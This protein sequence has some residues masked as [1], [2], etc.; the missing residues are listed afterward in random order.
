M[1][2]DVSK[3]TKAEAAAFVPVCPF[4][5]RK[6]GAYKEPEPLV[7]VDRISDQV[8]VNKET[9]EV[10]PVVEKVDLQAE[11]QTWKGQCGL[12]YFKT[13]VA[14]G[15]AKPEDAHDDGKHGVDTRQ[16][17]ETIHEAHAQSEALSGVISDVAKSLGIKE[18]KAISEEDL[19]EK[20]SAAIAVQIK[21]QPAPETP[22]P[23]E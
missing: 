5:I 16:L 18:G 21:T 4:H 8:E 19:I 7:L 12:E 22:A 3:E 11:I 20:L 15:K 2:T 9:L 1:T 14:Q 13:L 17:P 23:K 10:R 6:P